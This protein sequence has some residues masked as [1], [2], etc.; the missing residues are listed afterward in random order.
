MVF[1]NIVTGMQTLLIVTEI[2]VLLKRKCCFETPIT[3]H[4]IKSNENQ[5]FGCISVLEN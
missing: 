2:M 1:Q 4:E 3:F 5:A